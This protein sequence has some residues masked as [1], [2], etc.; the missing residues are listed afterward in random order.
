MR[1]A[2]SGPSPTLANAHLPMT[3]LS[4]GVR[5]VTSLAAA[6]LSVSLSTCAGNVRCTSQPVQAALQRAL[7]KVYAQSRQ[8][9]D[10]Q[11]EV[12]DIIVVQEGPRAATCRAAMN[13]TVNYLGTRQKASAV[14]TFAA[15]R[16]ERGDIL[17]TLTE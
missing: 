5:I 7:D 3:S 8:L 14:A 4:P 6:V 11:V 12:A 13:I 1:G 15:E 17:V 16:T 10:V 2:A 9:A